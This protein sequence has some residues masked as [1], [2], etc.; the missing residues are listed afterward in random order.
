V[1]C[2]SG[3]VSP[4]QFRLQTGYVGSERGDIFD[5]YLTN[6]ISPV[7]AHIPLATLRCPRERLRSL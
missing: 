7:A 5:R 4:G 1:E 2:P 3:R 6:L